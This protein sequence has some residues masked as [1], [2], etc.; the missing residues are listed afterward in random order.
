MAAKKNTE[1]PILTRAESEIM[2][3]FWSRG[4]MTVSQLKALLSGKAYTSLATLVKI[5]ETKGYLTHAQQADARAYV[6]SPAVKPD[7]AR[8]HHVRDLVER[9]FGGRTSEL[10]TGLLDDEALTQDELEA[11]RAEIDERLG[12]EKRK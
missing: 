2:A 7:R 8:R 9:L 6:F 10:V 12:K 4:P 1:V 11:L 3:L 5:L